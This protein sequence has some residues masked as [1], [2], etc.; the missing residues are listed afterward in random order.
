MHKYYFTNM[1]LTENDW[2]SL[3]KWVVLSD[4]VDTFKSRLDR[5]WHNQPVYNVCNYAESTS[6]SLAI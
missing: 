4:I 3:P 1:A 5:F 6:E 2:N